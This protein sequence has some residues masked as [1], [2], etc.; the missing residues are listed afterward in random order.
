MNL[1]VAGLIIAGCAA[2][3]IGAM[4]LVRRKA[5]AGGYFADSDRASGIFGVLA[6]GFAVL[7]GFIVFL[8]FSSYDQTRTGAEVEAEVLTQQIQTAQFLPQEVTA[9]LSG[10][11]TC[12]GRYVVHREWPLLQDGELDDA[13]NPW[14][15]ELFNTFRTVQTDTP[16]EEAAYGKWLDQ[17]SERQEAR[18]DRLH[19]GEGILPGPLWI[20]LFFMAIII[21]A[22]MLFFADADERTLSQS[23]QMG[24]VVAVIVA[25]LL[26]IRLFNNPYSE[27]PGGLDPT[28]MQRTLDLI[29]RLEGVAEVGEP[30]CTSE[31][32]A[33]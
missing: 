30:P 2:I 12:Y 33:L 24:S 32:D 23:F 25:T 1:V 7:L 26:V 10:E 3:G 6:T 28:A 14:G 17:T 16:E 8:A 13:P 5:P 18:L 11:L 20:A 9:E 4:L 15:I 27:G 31:G 19:G 29:G 21:F 22:F